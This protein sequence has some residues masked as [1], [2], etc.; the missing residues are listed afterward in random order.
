MQQR[1]QLRN[2]ATKSPS[3]LVQVN[4]PAVETSREKTTAEGC[5]D[6]E[7]TLFLFPVMRKALATRAIGRLRNNTSS[8]TIN[9]A[10][11]PSRVLAVPHTHRCCIA[12]IL[13]RVISNIA[14]DDRVKMSLRRCDE[15]SNTPSGK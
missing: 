11:S 3:R 4:H 1:S 5:A 15:V 8:H 7:H 10:A 9:P 6:R 14:N 13:K 2:V 12:N